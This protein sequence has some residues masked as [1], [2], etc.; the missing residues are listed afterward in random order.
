MDT[1]EITVNRH[2]YQS[3]FTAGTLLVNGITLCT[4]EDAVR[5]VK[6]MHKTAIPAGRYQVIPWVFHSRYEIRPL[7]K[8]V[9]NFTGVYVHVGNTDIDTSGCLLI[10]KGYANGSLTNSRVGYSEFCD[11]L[12][13][14]WSEGKETWLTITDKEN[15]PWFDENI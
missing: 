9:P 3:H 14:A 13:Q 11:H 4:L 15:H 8:D 2:T 10:S 7:L 1:L 6:V 12:C 5:K